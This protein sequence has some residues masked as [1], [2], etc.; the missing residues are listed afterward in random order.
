MN[1]SFKIYVQNTPVYLI[2]SPGEKLHLSTKEEV[3][4][5]Q[6]AQPGEICSLFREIDQTPDHHPSAI[7]C[8]H[9]TAEVLYNSLLEHYNHEVAAGG[10]VVNDHNEVLLIFRRGCWDLPK[11]KLEEGED[12]ENAAKREVE[13]E[14]GVRVKELGD[15]LYSTFYTFQRK[16]RDTLKETRWYLMKGGDG[17]LQP[18]Q[19][20]DIQ[21]VR[22]VSRDEL[23]SYLADS[24]PSLM[25]VARAW[26]TLTNV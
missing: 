14:T 1:R 3:K 6:I 18:Q 7:F 17:D 16:G 8:P 11:G 21:E 4:T 15:L 22:W 20:E 9:C 5:L 2:N 24:F 25:D 23:T 13:E 12:W 19:E 10:L 26:Q